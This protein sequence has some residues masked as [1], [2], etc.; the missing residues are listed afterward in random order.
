[1]RYIPDAQRLQ[2]PTRVATAAVLKASPGR[3]LAVLIEG[4]TAAS[5]IDFTNDG[6]GSA[7]PLIGVTVPFTDS[8]ASAAS[9]YFL[10]LSHFGG[11]YFSVAIYAKLAG[12]GA[13]AYIWYD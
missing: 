3:V 13:I 7:D 4:G 11:V 5:S 2:N 6:D 12:T 1:M 10:D 9:T 8:D